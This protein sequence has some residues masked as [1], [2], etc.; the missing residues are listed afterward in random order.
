MK[1][2]PSTTGATAPKAA[3]SSDGS[4]ERSQRTVNGIAMGKRDG[5]GQGCNVKAG[6]KKIAGC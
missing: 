3:K 2:T 6:G 1:T 5:R 4:G